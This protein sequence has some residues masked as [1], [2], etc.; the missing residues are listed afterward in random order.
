MPVDNLC[1]PCNGVVLYSRDDRRRVFLNGRNPRLIR[2]TRCGASGGVQRGLAVVG[3]SS[4]QTRFCWEQRCA[5][6]NT[7][8]DACDF[9]D[10]SGGIRRGCPPGEG[11]IRYQPSIDRCVVPI[12]L[13]GSNPVRHQRLYEGRLERLTCEEADRELETFKLQRELKRYIQIA[14]SAKEES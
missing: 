4:L 5:F 2:R 13:E 14:K 1:S 8:V 7:V 6:Y 12:V 10:R 9:L 11:C 3:V